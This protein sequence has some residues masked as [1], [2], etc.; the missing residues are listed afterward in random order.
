MQQRALSSRVAVLACLS[1]VGCAVSTAEPDD[2][3][4]EPR[5]GQVRQA[6]TLSCASQSSLKRFVTCIHNAMPPRDSNDYVFPSATAI[7]DY[8]N[9]VAQML[10]GQCSSIVLPASLD[11]Y[12]RVTQ[13]VDASMSNRTYCVL[14]EDTDANGDGNVDR[15]WGTFVY[16]ANAKNEVHHTAAH[17]LADTD[18]DYQALDVFQLAESRALS[19]AGAHRN[20]NAALSSC[21]GDLG[22]YVADG[23]HNVETFFEGQLRVKAHQESLGRPYYNI[24]WH[25]MAAD[26]CPQ[27]AYITKGG[28][29]PLSPSDKAYQL[30][31]DIRNR[32]GWNIGWPGDGGSS[33]DLDGDTNTFARY[34]NG[35]AASQVCSTQP[36]TAT[37]G[38][39]HIEQDLYNADGEG[40]RVGSKWAA[41]I[42]AVFGTGTPP[43]PSDCI[44]SGAGKPC[45]ATTNCCSGV[46]NCTGGTPKNRTC[47]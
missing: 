20:A 23:A 1:F 7:A 2:G 35:A 40:I 37:G 39:I 44:A 14:W 28:A 21:Q 18:T 36:P 33:C 30:A 5:T 16:Y 34:V 8:G 4:L 3:S 19:I 31:I 22:Y 42:A 11:P 38:F 43:P 29:Y 24:Q 32:Q 9:V 15:G 6:V 17:P 13:Y 26:S 27:H 47:R 10:A 12:Y 41:S 46:G 45:K 25:G